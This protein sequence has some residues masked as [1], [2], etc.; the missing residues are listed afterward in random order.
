MWFAWETFKRTNPSKGP[1]D[2]Y[3]I[4]QSIQPLPTTERWVA[5]Q[6]TQK[7][8]Q[9]KFSKNCM[10][11]KVQQ[12]ENQATSFVFLFGNVGRWRPDNK[13]KATAEKK[14]K[15]WTSNENCHKMEES[16]PHVQTKSK[17]S[18]KIHPL[19]SFLNYYHIKKHSAKMFS[20]W[21]SSK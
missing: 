4:E 7:H 8:V 5:P 16:G 15:K 9:M 6:S 3:L 1:T 2:F 17:N 19:R 11:T 21:W 14:K 13:N 10:H 18:T 20:N 12:Y